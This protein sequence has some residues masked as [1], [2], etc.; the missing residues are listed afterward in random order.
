MAS[1]LQALSSPCGKLKLKMNSMLTS[2]YRLIF[3]LFVVFLVKVICSFFIYAFLNIDFTDTYWMI[4]NWDTEGQNTNLRTVGQ[5]GMRWPYL[6]LGWDSAWYFSIVAKGY[7]FSGKSFAFFPGY[8]ASSWIVNLLIH[9]PAISIIALSIV[10]GLLSIPVYQLVMEQY[11]DNAKAVK[12]TLLYAFFPYVFL[13][14]TVAYGEGL[15]LLLTMTAWYFLKK[16]RIGI[17]SA[18]ATL[19]TFVRAPGAV[20]L[21]PMAMEANK[22]RKGHSRR[23]LLNIFL[24]FAPLFAY[25]SWLLYSRYTFGSWL[26]TGWGGM[27]SVSVLLFDLLPHQGLT[28]LLQVFNIWPYSLFFIPFVLIAPFLIFYASRIDKLLGLYSVMYFIGIL[29]AGALA[30][31]P[32]FLSFIFPLWIPLTLKLAESKRSNINVLL[33]CSVS[34]LIGVFLWINFVNGVFIA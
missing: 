21:F 3:P 34:T 31:I 10:P 6:F 33:T 5:Q 12:L 25:F 23:F 17:T 15:F 8:P 7:A 9:N 29:A 1:G 24:A 11:F 16:H 14:T 18:F 13:F 32:R 19:S 4:V 22:T 20:M 27:Y 26:P 28:P 30:S 2:R